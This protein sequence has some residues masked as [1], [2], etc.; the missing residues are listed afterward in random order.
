MANP[1]KM[2]GAYVSNLSTNIGWGGQGGTMQLK[3]VEDPDNGVEIRRGQN[4]GQIFTGEEVVD[5]DTGAVLADMVSDPRAALTHLE[6][7]NNG[8]L[9]G[10]P[11]IGTPVYFKYSNGGD[12]GVG[13]EAGFFFGGIFQ[14]Y[15]YSE[16]VGSGKIYDIVIESPSSFMDGVQVIVDEYNGITDSFLASIGYGNQGYLST[17]VGMSSTEDGNAD[18]MFGV[19]Y[20]VAS[21]GAITIENVYNLF[22]YFEN[23][24]L[25]S[26]ESSFQYRN[27][28]G[29]SNFNSAGVEVD[30]LLRALKRLAIR[31][32]PFVIGG[33]INLGG[34]KCTL[35]VDDMIAEVNRFWG[36]TAVQQK[37]TDAYRMKGPVKTVNGMLGEI[38][39][40]LQ[41]D[42]FYN[43]LPED[44][45]NPRDPTT[46]DININWKDLANG[47]GSLPLPVI[48]V[49]TVDKGSQPTGG[50]IESYINQEKPKGN[51][52]SYNL[53]KEYGNA[54]TQKMVVGGKR[55]RYPIAVRRNFCYPVWGKHNGVD[56]NAIVEAGEGTPYIIGP[57]IGNSFGADYGVPVQLDNSSIRDQIYKATIFEL[58][59]AMGG[60]ECWE[61]FKTFETLAR[62]EQNTGRLRNIFANPSIDTNDLRRCPW[63]GSFDATADVLRLLGDE[64]Q[65]NAFMLQSTNLSDTYKRYQTSANKTADKIF[66]AVATV[67][68][69]FYC[70]EWLVPMP[71][72]GWVNDSNMPPT[73]AFGV[74]GTRREMQYGPPGDYIVTNAWEVSDSAY[75]QKPVCMDISMFDSE[76]KQKAVAAWPNSFQT[77][78]SA[79]GSDYGM[80]TNDMSGCV[81]STKGSPSPEVYWCTSALSPPGDFPWVHFKTGAAPKY[82][83]SITTPDWG[84]TVLAK[85]FF[86]I[87][88]PPKAYFKTGFNGALQ[89]GIPPDNA[90]P[91]FFGIPQE[92]TRYSYGPWLTLAGLGLGG[93][94]G[95]SRGVDVTGRAEVEINESLRPEVFGG[96]NNLAHMGAI[97]ATVGVGKMTENESGSVEAVG[98]PTGNIGERFAGGGPYLTNMSISVDATAGI[99]TTYKFNTWS[100]TFGKLAK[101]N[102]DRISRI[103]KASWAFAQ[104]QRGKVEKPPFPKKKFEK[105]D[106][107]LMGG[108]RGVDVGALNEIFRDGKETNTQD[109]G[110]QED[111]GAGRGTPTDNFGDNF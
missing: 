85:Y 37:Q 98:A 18:R 71:N 28:F 21:N 77:D 22:A 88:I 73:N 96:Y 25:P 44:P 41:L 34:H 8:V 53:G 78:F 27:L 15:T 26:E 110:R 4:T 51:I 20:G 65:G 11:K 106:V 57:P 82:Y 24:L 83:D 111:G 99:K 14:K 92:S 74:T 55:T 89:F 48:S 102:I 35:L 105:S 38:A 23:P 19:R 17:T 36:T 101:Y 46:G 29:G 72:D 1:V 42:Y 60:K 94:L 5:K 50:A 70:Q 107:S 104:K 2:F 84:L 86:D 76:S 75:I 95:I 91:A 33:P 79:L 16:S 87:D 10:S 3:L 31:D 61:A 39:D 64:D 63:T 97:M 108:R 100:P 43:I 45:K 93:G 56:F 80:G 40:V 13:S 66:A 52:I 90:L 81:V 103:N 69:S 7:V 9:A 62:V 30:R 109:M 49:K 54:V 32:C 6:P 47:G 12:N 58:R 59:M 68:N 67:A